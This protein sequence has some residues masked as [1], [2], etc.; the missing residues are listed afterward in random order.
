MC[1]IEDNIFEILF[2][3][4]SDKDGNQ[5][6][7]VSKVHYDT[8]YQQFELEHTDGSYTIIIPSAPVAELYFGKNVKRVEY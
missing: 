6:T 7:D 1:G 3:T 8:E 2:G 4:Q 5:Y